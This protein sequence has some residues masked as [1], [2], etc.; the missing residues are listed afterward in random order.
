MQLAYPLM[1]G[2]AN[3]K[4]L[5]ESQ[6]NF[7]R[8]GACEARFAGHVRAPL[9]EE[10]RACGWRLFDPARDPHLDE[11]SPDDDTR[12]RSAAL[13]INIYYWEPGYW[14]APHE[15]AGAESARSMAA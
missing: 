1:E 7:C 12:W 8:F 9:P 2:G 13:E 10:C 15:Y 4:C 6:E 14:L 5:R 3:A 11:L